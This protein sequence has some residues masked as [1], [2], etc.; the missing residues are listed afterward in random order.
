MNRDFIKITKNDGSTEKME[1]VAT[2]KLESTSKNYIIYKT[3][4]PNNEH[5]YAASYNPE[6]NY[7]ELNTNLSKEEKEALNK[8]FNELRKEI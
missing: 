4:N 1:L 2:F 6:T 3:L 5:Y 7:S 8:I